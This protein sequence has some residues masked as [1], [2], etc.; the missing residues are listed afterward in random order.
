MAQ[1]LT[2]YEKERNER[3]ARRIIEATVKKNPEEAIPDT[4]GRGWKA[5]MLAR[6]PLIE[7]E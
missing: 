1:S 2:E 7:K 5:D 4:G 6:N 3:I